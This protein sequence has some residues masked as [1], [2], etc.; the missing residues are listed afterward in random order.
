LESHDHGT[1]TGP[2]LRL[3]PAWEGRLEELGRD[4]ADRV[5]PVRILPRAPE[6]YAG[7]SALVADQAGAE[8]LL[9]F[10]RQRPI[11]FIGIDCEYRYSRPGVFVRR[12]RGKDHNWYDPHSLVPLLLAVVLGETRPDGQAVL[13]RFVLDLRQPGVRGPLGAFFRL[14]VP[15]VAHFA[16]AELFCLWKLA[17]P[18]PDSVWDTCLAERAFQLGVHHPRYKGGGSED[19]VEQARSKEEA[20]AEIDFSCNLVSTCQRRGVPYP[21]AA[22]KERLQASFLTHPEDQPFSPEQQAYVAA[23]AEAAARLYP[24]QVQAALV[25]NALNHLQQVEMD[26]T[27]TNARIIWDGVRADP[28]LCEQ[29]RQACERHIGGLSAQLTEQGL[30]NV[31]SHTQLKEFFRTIGLLDAFRAGA[32][33]TFDDDHLE[34]VEDH[35]VAVPL[36]RTLRKIQRLINDQLLTGALVGADGRL[37]PDHKQLGAASGRNTM[38]NPNIGGIG[39]PLRPLVVPDDP[40]THAIGEVDLSQIEVGVAA[41]LFGD[42]DL[43]VMFNRGDVYSTMARRYYAD[44]L[45]PEASGLPDREFRKVYRSYRDRMKVFTLAII[46]NITAV[47]LAR[48]LGLGRPQAARERE[49]F[50]ALFPSLVRAL[51][52]ASAYGAIRGYAELC[53]GLRRY[54]ARAGSPTPWEVN[55]LRNTPVQGSAGVV[56]K[57]A[58]NRL[59]RRYP[60]Y[61]AKI[62]LC[63]HDAFLFEVPRTHLEAV[64]GITGEVMRG[65]VQEYFPALDPQVDVNIEHPQCWNK[66]GKHLSLEYWMEDPERARTY[67]RS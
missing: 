9:D 36:I 25:Q 19:E 3:A 14:P 4:R 1:R 46:Y 23:D 20:E 27:V 21:F 63:L 30:G 65:A 33:Y 40:A 53:T 52:E 45:P 34:A 29:L 32:K 26:W 38:S 10:A 67:L 41:A 55:W 59:R 58:G 5:V 31:N 11:A 66:D 57:V 60:H 56:F 13:Y 8:E 35:H 39:K 44:R 49:K 15:F 54:R 6:Y 51:G 37:H 2:K 12:S 24:I 18:T 48:Q 62:I 16:Q 7:E 61:G 17:L 64:A 50:L 28:A 22:A 47:G 43:I 42:P